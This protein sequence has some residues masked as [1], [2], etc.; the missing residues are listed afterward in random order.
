MLGPLLF[1]L[2]VADLSDLVK[3]NIVQ[4]DDCSLEHL[5]ERSEDAD[6]LQEVFQRDLQEDLEMSNAQKR[7]GRTRRSAR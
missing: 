3:T 2:F 6:K 7:N 4:H 5:I 1:N